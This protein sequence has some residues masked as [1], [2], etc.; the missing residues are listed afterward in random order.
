MK[1]NIKNNEELVKKIIE[2]LQPK[3]EEAVKI[4][5]NFIINVDKE[6]VYKTEIIDGREC[7]KLYI[8]SRSAFV[9][10]KV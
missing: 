6:Y 5:V 9:L 2:L 4:N 7:I 10:K 1:R 8:P 3:C